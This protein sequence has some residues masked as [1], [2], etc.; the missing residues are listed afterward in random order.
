MEGVPE[1]VRQSVEELAV[2]GHKQIVNLRTRCVI[3]YREHEPMDL[4]NTAISSFRARIWS[5]TQTKAANALVNWY[6]GWQGP[7][8]GTQ[9]VDELVQILSVLFF[10]STLH[11]IRFAWCEGFTQSHQ[12]LACT[13]WGEEKS[14]AYIFADPSVPEYASIG[15]MSEKDILLGI[16]MH[17]CAHAFLILYGCPRTCGGCLAASSG[18]GHGRAWFCLAINMQAIVRA[19][20]GKDIR[21]FAFQFGPEYVPCAEDWE[22]YYDK[23]QSQSPVEYAWPFVS[24]GEPALDELMQLCI[25]RDS[26]V[27]DILRRAAIR[28]GRLDLLGK[29]DVECGTV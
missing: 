22:R 18:D 13:Y 9:P 29:L 12:I 8:A 26:R 6:R 25:S 7:R 15:A 20:L 4:I 27:R 1:I 28:H 3:E 23:D 24:D 16:V 19:I 14:Y 10:C 21:L 11:E 2:L 17:E 5:S